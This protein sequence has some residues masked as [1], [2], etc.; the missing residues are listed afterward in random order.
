MPE[1]AKLVFKGVLFDVYQWEQTMF[2]GSVET[3]EKLRRPNTS[4]VVASVGGKILMQREEQPDSGQFLSIP[5]GRCDEG[6]SLLE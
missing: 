6:E 2:D 1:N 5:G 4:A 3:F